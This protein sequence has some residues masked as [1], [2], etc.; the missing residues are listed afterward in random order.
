VRGLI[1]LRAL[2][3]DDVEAHK[4]SNGS[5]VTMRLFVLDM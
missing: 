4:R 5:L 2:T 3:H 1:T